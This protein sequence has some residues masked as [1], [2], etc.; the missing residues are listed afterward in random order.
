MINFLIVFNKLKRWKLNKCQS[1]LLS[2]LDL[3]DLLIILI[4]IYNNM[5]HFG[6]KLEK[7]NIIKYSLIN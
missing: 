2:Y 6:D 3:L 7:L 5:T 4:F 1:E